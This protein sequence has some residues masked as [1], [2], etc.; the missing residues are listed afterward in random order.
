MQE[1]KIEKRLSTKIPCSIE[2]FVGK[3]QIER[4]TFDQDIITIG[5]DNSCDIVINNLGASRLHA[6]IERY[7]SFYILKDLNSKTGTFVG[8]NKTSNDYNLNSNDKIFLAKHTLS[9]KMDNYFNAEANVSKDAQKDLMK[10]TL[11]INFENMASK[12]LDEVGYLY[13]ADEKKNIPLQ[14]N[15][16][17]LGKSDKSDVLISGMLV[18]ERHI[19]IVKEEKEYF[20]YHLG[21]FK[22]PQLNKA[23][24]DFSPL[25]HGDIVVIGDL[26][27]QFRMQK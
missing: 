12:N 17:F 27:F 23:A 7:A 8:G 2:I 3:D 20:I 25:K 26:H 22:P 9:F 4:L 5:R 24:V 1:N 21:A 15:I 10:Q 13:I 11:A 16:T 14:K 6:Q 18:S 19:A